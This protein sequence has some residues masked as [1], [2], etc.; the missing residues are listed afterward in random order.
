MMRLTSLRLFVLLLIG[1]MLGS[2][3]QRS[4]YQDYINRQLREYYP[5]EMEQYKYIVVMPRRGCHACIRAA[6]TFYQTVRN[7]SSYLFIF[8]RVASLK[9]LEL[10]LGKENVHANNV[11]IDD[12]SLFYDAQ[13]PDSKYP[14][15]LRK[16]EDG[17]FS[18]KKLVSN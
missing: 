10:E 16:E 17:V 6:E 18:Y 4:E 13:Y 3:S 8:T 5:L 9:L 7:D 14:L 12:N 15:F 2:C 11:R 1:L